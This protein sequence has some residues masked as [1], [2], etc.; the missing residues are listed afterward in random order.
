MLERQHP[1][2]GQSQTGFRKVECTLLASI[3]VVPK[4][5]WPTG[6]LWWLPTAVHLRGRHCLHAQRHPFLRVCVYSLLYTFCLYYMYKI[7][8]QY[9]QAVTLASP[10]CFAQETRYWV[11]GVT[12]LI[13]LHLWKRQPNNKYFKVASSCLPIFCMSFEDKNFLLWDGAE[14]EGIPTVLRPVKTMKQKW[15]QG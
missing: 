14:Q 5:F 2:F 8:R 13:P 12:Y 3:P 11:V 7:L 9:Y 10:S 1:E 4:P 6:H 15:G